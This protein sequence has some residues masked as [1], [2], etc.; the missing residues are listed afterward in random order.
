VALGAQEKGEARSAVR[1]LSYGAIRGYHRYFAL[2][3]LLSSKS[4]AAFDPLVQAVLAVAFFELEDAR[5]PAYAVVDAAV[6]SIK[7][8][9][10]ARAQ[11]LIN[12]LL[13]RYL[14]ERA[15]LDAEVRLKP[16]T[17][18][19]APKWLA[20]TLRETY[21]SRWPE[22]L[23][24]LDRQA[25]MWLRVDAR[26][27]TGADY[28][29]TLAEAGKTASVHPQVAQAVLLAEPCDVAELP[30]FAEGLVS[31]QDLSA[32]C[33]IY[34]LALKPH[35]NVL[36][37][38][39]APGGKTALMA[40]REPSLC[41]TA[42]DSDAA[43]LKR[44]EATLE[45][46][47][48]EAKIE[49]ADAAASGRTQAGAPFDRILIDAPCSALGVIRRHPDI[50]VRKGAADLNR[51]PPLQ[52][53]LL[54]AAWSMLRCGGRL[55]FAT[56]TITRTENHDVIARFLD[57]T[58]GAELV[59]PEQWEGWPA[60]GESDGIGRQILPGESGADGFFYAAI[61]KT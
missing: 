6:E 24:A 55:V 56:C 8:G 11:G 41:I 42:L 29:A 50:K 46:C 47:R 14:R 7:A 52:G 43:R 57:A 15:A 34:P 4:P 23:A 25:P 45:R 38:C 44:L 5:T 30:G 9:A 51:L 61:D 53:A 32:Q 26:R 58:A 59:P 54:K 37:A 16:A 19:A 18:H 27:M 21:P 10:A 28:L 20:D 49:L 1:S 40:E 2:W 60:L 35:L 13:R 17:C 33:A 12:A 48:V 3:K 36:D 39:A 31:V 22:I